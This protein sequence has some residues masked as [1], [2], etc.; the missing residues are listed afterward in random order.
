MFTVEVKLKGKLILARSCNRIAGQ[1]GGPCLYVTD[2][3]RF[4]EHHYDA[5]AAVLATLL[6]SGVKNILTAAHEQ[7]AARWERKQYPEEIDGL[8]TLQPQGSNRN[9]RSARRRKTSHKSK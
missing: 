8:T 7:R 5:G 6:L 1:Q 2:D 4:I 3:G 9:R